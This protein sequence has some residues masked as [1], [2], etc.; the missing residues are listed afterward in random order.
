MSS[1]TMNILV[2]N[3]RGF[4]HPLKHKEVRNLVRKF[5]MFGG[6]KS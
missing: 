1:L 2:W 3:I 6:N 5:N 4:T